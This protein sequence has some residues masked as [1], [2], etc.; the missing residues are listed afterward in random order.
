MPV[1][2]IV[3]HPRPGDPL[4]PQVVVEFEVLLTRLDLHFIKPH[5]WDRLKTLLII[6][7]LEAGDADMGRLGYERAL[8]KWKVSRFNDGHE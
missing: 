7:T 2:I 1:S 8:A 3:G 5:E 6:A 4:P